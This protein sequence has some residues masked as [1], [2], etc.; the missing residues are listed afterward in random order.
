MVNRWVKSDGLP[1]VVLPDGSL[2]FDRSDLA[3]WVQSRK[4]SAI[5]Q[6]KGCGCQKRKAAMNRVIPGSGDLLESVLTGIGF[7]QTGNGSEQV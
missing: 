4:Q 6:A 5:E 2:R 1:H 3:E 7:K